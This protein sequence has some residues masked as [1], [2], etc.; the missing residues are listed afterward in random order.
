MLRDIAT[1]SRESFGFFDVTRDLRITAL[2]ALQVINQLA[3]I[4]DATNE[5]SEAESIKAYV[6]DDDD[7]EEYGTTVDLVGLADDRPDARAVSVWATAT[8]NTFTRMTQVSIDWPRPES[9]GTSLSESQVDS[10]P[11]VA[12]E[13]LNL[14]TIATVRRILD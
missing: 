10:A 14:A 4:P 8:A 6:T 11:Q 2:D 12:V 7:E 3:A 5:L 9:S 1:V 13:G